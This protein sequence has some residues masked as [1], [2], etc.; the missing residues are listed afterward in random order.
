VATVFSLL[1]TLRVVLREGGIGKSSCVY[2]GCY[3][4]FSACEDHFK[5]SGSSQDAFCQHFGVPR[6]EFHGIPLPGEGYPG[7][8]FGVPEAVGEASGL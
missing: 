4:L 5:V 6:P 1:A 3:A 8:H 2:Q 7:F